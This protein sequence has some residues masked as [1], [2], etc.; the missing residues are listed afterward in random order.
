[1]ND[2]TPKISVL[3]LSQAFDK[4]YKGLDKMQ[5]TALETEE[6]YK[7]IPSDKTEVFMASDYDNDDNSIGLSV[8]V[9]N[10][11]KEIN[12]NEKCF[13]KI[14]SEYLIRADISKFA[15][16]MQCINLMERKG[17]DKYSIDFIPVSYNDE[18]KDYYL[19]FTITKEL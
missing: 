14:M 13:D 2:S 17:T 16:I 9:S 6:L 15:N 19:Q 1:M 5:V 12:P 3:K 10:P 18:L 11:R 7:I 4:I 8:F